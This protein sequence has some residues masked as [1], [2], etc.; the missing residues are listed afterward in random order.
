MSK[1]QQAKGTRYRV[2]V[3]DD[4]ERLRSSVCNMLLERSQE[5][6]IRAVIE[7]PDGASALAAARA[8]KPDVVVMDIN[9]PGMSGLKVAAC[10]K[11]L[12]PSL[13]V[14]LMTAAFE[15]ELEENAL[16]VGVRAVLDKTDLWAALPTV[17]HAV[18]P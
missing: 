3:V 10:L 12:Q 15:R 2:L 4:N 18:L 7:A 14:V 1:A 13:P 6:D 11:A 9:M 5:L 8:L 17:L 16:G